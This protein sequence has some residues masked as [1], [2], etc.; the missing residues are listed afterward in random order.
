MRENLQ[1]NARLFTG[2]S[3]RGLIY[4]GIY[5]E[6]MA[7]MMLD[8]I[9]TTTEGVSSKEEDGKKKPVLE[10]YPDLDLD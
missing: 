4:H 6:A 9:L 1:E 7:D 10:R 5:G 3:G 8:N 2:Q